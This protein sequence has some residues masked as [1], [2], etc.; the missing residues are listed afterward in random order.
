RL[1]RQSNRTRPSSA[2]WERACP[3]KGRLVLRLRGQARS[4]LSIAAPCSVGAALA[5]KRGAW[6]CDFAGKPAPISASQRP[7]PWE[8]PWPRKRR[9][10]LRLRGQARS[11]R[12]LLPRAVAPTAEAT[13]QD[14]RRTPDTGHP[15]PFA[16]ALPAFFFSL[17]QASASFH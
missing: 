1:P 8:R 4:H 5:A 17:V 14:D 6:S 13:A 9:L 2:S 12:Q 15:T 10:V 3:R 11:H 7:V 16:L